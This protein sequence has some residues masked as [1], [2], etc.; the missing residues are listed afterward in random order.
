MIFKNFRLKNKEDAYFK[1]RISNP[2]T[3]FALFGTKFERVERNNGGSG[4][5]APRKPTK[6]YDF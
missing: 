6:K 4:G 3:N 2:A 1:E 5:G